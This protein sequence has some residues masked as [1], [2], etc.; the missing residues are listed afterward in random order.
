LDD[1][2][3]G[4]GNDDESVGVKKPSGGAKRRRAIAGDKQI[5]E[6]GYVGVL[7]QLSEV[8][9]ESSSSDSSDSSSSR[10]NPKC[11][12]QRRSAGFSGG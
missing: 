12:I 3:D 4:S 8:E 6:L 11:R 9:D 1:S 2:T 7:S 5:E 10:M